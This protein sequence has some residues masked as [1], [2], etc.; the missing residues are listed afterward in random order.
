MPLSPLSGRSLLR[1]GILFLI[2]ILLAGCDRDQNTATY[3]PQFTSHPVNTKIE[4]VFGVNLLQHPTKVQTIFGPLVAYLNANISDASFRLEATQNETFRSKLTA[5]NLDFA[6]HNPYQ[7][8]NSLKYGYRVFAKMADDQNFRGII[9]VRKDGG[10]HQI[11]DLKGKKV[12]SPAPNALA[13][14][15]MPQYYLQTHG[16]NVMHDI[17][18]LYVG[19]QESS[20]MNLYQ[21]NVAA[22]TTWIPPWRAFIKER[23]EI[24]HELQVMWTTDPLPNNGLVVRDDIPAN[25]ANQV[26]NL[27]LNLHQT[28]QGR[29]ILTRMNLSRFEPATEGTYQPVREFLNN[30]E[31]QVR[32]LE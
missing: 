32:P 24:A 6:L 7:T 26:Q 5:R 9:L 8:L 16:I 20:I 31:K 4:Y 27:I 13:A 30:F 11:N 1:S 10:I 18:T 29:E 3:A 25:I 19:S 12:S 23:P 22:A 28:P 17:T 15:M 14:T 2:S 21:G